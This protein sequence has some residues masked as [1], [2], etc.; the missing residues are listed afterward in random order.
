[1]DLKREM[2]RERE[3]EREKG[4]CLVGEEASPVE[5]S[6]VLDGASQSMTPVTLKRATSP[7]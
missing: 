7:R 3:W 1:M 4:V 2:E 6:E 5:F